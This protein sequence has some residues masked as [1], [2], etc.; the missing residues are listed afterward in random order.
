M[1]LRL[2]ISCAHVREAGFEVIPL[3]DQQMFVGAF[4]T[5]QLLRKSY[6]R[7]NNCAAFYE[8]QELKDLLKSKNKHEKTSGIVPFSMEKYSLVNNR[9]HIS[10]VCGL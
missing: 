9:R 2:M 3:L 10:F 5:T 8:L 6:W 1:L 7:F 4:I